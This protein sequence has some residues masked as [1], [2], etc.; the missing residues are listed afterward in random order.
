MRVI[1]KGDR[2]RRLPVGDVALE[3]L[4]RYVDDVRPQLLAER[5]A[6][7]AA[8]TTRR[9]GP[10]FLTDRGAAAG[11]DGRVAHVR[12]AALRGGRDGPR[13]TAHVAS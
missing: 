11:P 4:R 8:G 9:G 7:V 1:G 5:A 12:R 2:E 10:L 13:D 3:A 6:R